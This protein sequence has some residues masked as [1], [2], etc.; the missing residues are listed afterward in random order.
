M[1]TIGKQI[2]SFRKEK[3][4]NQCTV[5]ERITEITGSSIT[6]YTI[7]N[8]ESGARNVPVQL[9]TV[10]AE[11]FG[12]TTDRLL[13]STVELPQLETKDGATLRFRLNN[14][15]KAVDELKAENK[16]LKQKLKSVQRKVENVIKNLSLE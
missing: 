15:L 2:K 3:G 9:V 1:S 7:S 6:K 13:Y 4:M 11:I 5:A 10:F 8:Y 14:A 12:V 16:E